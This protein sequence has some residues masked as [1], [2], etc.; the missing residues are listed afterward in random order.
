MDERGNAGGHQVS[1]ASAGSRKPTLHQSERLHFI[2]QNYRCIE[3]GIGTESV[4]DAVETLHASHPKVADLLDTHDEEIL[5]VY[6]LP[7]HHRN[8]MSSSKML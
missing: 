1:E 3:S 4:W 8:R 6:T 5:A 2:R 7:E